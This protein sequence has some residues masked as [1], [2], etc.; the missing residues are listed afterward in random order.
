[1]R[2]LYVYGIVEADA[3]DDAATLGPGLAGATLRLQRCECDLT[4]LVAEADG[5]LPEANRRNLLT[6]TAVLERA[7]ARADVLPMRFA[8][9]APDARHLDDCLSRNAA[10]FRAA[11]AGIA[12]RIELGVKASWRDGVAFREILAAD[13]G[14]RAQRDRLQSRLGGQIYQERIALGRQ[15]EAAL[16]KLRAADCA[17]IKARLEPLAERTT[18][19]KQL[20]ETMVM[21]RAFLVRREVEPAFDAAMRDI[22]QSEDARMSF[23]YIGPVPPYNFVTLRA[24][25]L[26]QVA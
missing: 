3:L 17:A 8:T 26:G 12:G 2:A 6:H 24:D 5:R 18:G 7:I 10:L 25:W 21:N 13:P 23:R 15:V 1:M 20:E 22:A 9:I 19:L 11:L 14:L 4:A 16:E